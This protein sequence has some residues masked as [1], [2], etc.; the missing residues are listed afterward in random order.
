MAW[1]AKAHICSQISV[2]ADALILAL[3]GG[4]GSHFLIFQ[5]HKFTKLRESVSCNKRCNPH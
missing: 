4:F 5:V 1:E 3:G 2:L